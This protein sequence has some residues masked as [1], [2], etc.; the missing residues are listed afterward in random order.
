[1]FI[2]S[3][4]H[5]QLIDYA[6]L[7][8]SLEGV[9][10]QAKEAGVE[11]MLCVSTTLEDREAILKIV[12]SAPNIYASLGLHPNEI[13]KKEPEISDLLR[14]VDHP[15]II[16]IGETG[17]DYYRTEAD[18]HYQ[19]A[20]FIVHIQAAKISKKPLIIH[21]RQAKNDTLAI[22]KSEKAI[23]AG[24]VFHC[25]TEDWETAE[26]ALDLGFYISL[27]GIVTFKNAVELKQV[28][29]KV[30]LD[31]LLIETDA[32]YLAPVPYRGKI[33]QPAYVKQ[34]AEYIAELR[35]VSLETLSRQT[36][37]NFNRLFLKEASSLY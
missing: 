25:F 22:L 28:A 37:D 32:P 12:E 26:K 36:T 10:Q 18:N 11:K 17:L 35:E 30:P 31:H 6:E 27:S 24:G 8:Q 4:C 33:N 1:M 21:T 5:L 23:D 3:H 20:R 15:K 29:K 9:L 34:V 16:A 13:I 2:D 7:G 14:L 19:K